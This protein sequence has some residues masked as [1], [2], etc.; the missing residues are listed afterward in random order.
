M[1]LHDFQLYCRRPH[2]MEST[3]FDFCAYSR[4]HVRCRRC[5][6]ASG[7]PETKSAASAQD[8]W[9]SDSAALL[10]RSAAVIAPSRFIAK[11]VADLFSDLQIGDK[12]CVIKNERATEP[13]GS[14]RV[15]ED[16]GERVRVVF[17]GQFTRS[18]GSA[19]FAQIAY[20]LARDPRFSFRVVGGIVDHES[21][22]LA[23]AA[24]RV[25]TS[26][27][28]RRERL[29]ELLDADTDV[30]ALVSVVPESWSYTLT[31]VLT[32]GTPVLA[33][34]LGA[35]GERLRRMGR[36]RWLVPRDEGAAGFVRR[37]REHAEGGLQWPRGAVEGTWSSEQVAQQH[38]EL[39]ESC[40]KLARRE[41][42]FS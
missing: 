25:K 36:Q 17:V 8:E 37:L 16:A 7:M 29:A 31:E 35:V 3:T 20:A 14:S 38:A 19:V 4:D 22:R 18:K 9:R 11:A 33:F 28:Y 12:T 34:D 42:S 6:E 5:L 24:T 2:L 10:R 21:L 13:S 30:V 1:S 27:W 23:R 41:S 26:G 39:Y 32:A 15:G 40:S